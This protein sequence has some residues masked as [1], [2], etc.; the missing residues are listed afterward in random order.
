VQKK[1]AEDGIP[2]CRITL[3]IEE[4]SQCSMRALLRDGPCCIGQYLTSA[5]GEADSGHELTALC[6]SNRPKDYACICS[7]GMPGLRL[8]RNYQK[9]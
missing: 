1:N 7:C 3:M 2:F 5:T 9:M 8:L 4:K 6:D